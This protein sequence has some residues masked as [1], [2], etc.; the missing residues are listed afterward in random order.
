MGLRTV[1][2]WDILPSHREVINVLAA[3]I[4]F[5]TGNAV[6]WRVCSEGDDST[7]GPYHTHLPL[8]YRTTHTFHEPS[9]DGQGSVLGGL[10][11]D[12]CDFVV[13]A[14]YL[15]RVDQYPTLHGDQYPTLHGD[16]YP[17]LHGDQ[18]PTLHGDQYPTL[19][20]DQY[21]TLHGDSSFVRIY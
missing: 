10:P 3:R 18:Y 12:P 20:G 14:S 13:G 4:H 16:Q 1:G 6:S 2:I 9:E 15:L 5:H 19:H 21:P 8:R 17:T 11:V 7:E